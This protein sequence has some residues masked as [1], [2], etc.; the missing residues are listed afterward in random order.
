MFVCIVKYKELLYICFSKCDLCY[1]TDSPFLTSYPHSL[2]L[3]F[4][5][6]Y[7]LILFSLILYDA[8]FPTLI[9]LEDVVPKFFMIKQ[10]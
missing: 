8:K 3:N 7:L 5:V 10:T 6:I 4:L 2:L 9:E 1:V